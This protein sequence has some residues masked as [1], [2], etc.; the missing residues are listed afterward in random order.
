MNRLLRDQEYYEKMSEK[1]Q[2]QICLA[3]VGEAM[4]NYLPWTVGST[5]VGA[6]AG[7][8]AGEGFGPIGA[9]YGLLI[10]VWTAGAQTYFEGPQCK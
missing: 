9:G 1:A 6:G 10:G 5:A 2:R 4:R 8:A 3:S 7:L